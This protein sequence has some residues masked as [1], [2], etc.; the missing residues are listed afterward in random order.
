M[1]MRPKALVILVLVCLPRPLRAEAQGSIAGE[2]RIKNSKDFADTVV[3]LLDVKGKWAPRKAVLA[4]KNKRLVP[5][6]LPILIGSTVDFPNFDPIFHNVYSL[7]KI[8]SFD[9]GLYAQGESRSQSFDAPGVVD[10]YCSIHS[11]MRATI[12]VRENP[13]F[14]VTDGSGRFKIANVPAG[15]YEAAVWRG[16]RVSKSMTVSVKSKAASKIEL[17]LKKEPEE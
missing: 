3:Y 13:F 15:T 8:K 2:I 12:L 9:L 14:A 11:A 16:G 10:V 1:D 4:Q 5:A 6:V 7:S 17:V